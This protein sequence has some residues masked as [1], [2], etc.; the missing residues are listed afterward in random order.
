MV[1]HWNRLPGEVVSHHPWKCSKNMEMWHFGTWFSRHGG[2]GVAVG[3]DDLRGFSNLCFYDS[4]LRVVMPYMR[5]KSEGE[6]APVRNG[7]ENTK[8]LSRVNC[9]CKNIKQNPEK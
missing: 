1:R 5:K 3:L 6:K 4:I 2:V 8:S 7:T 9:M